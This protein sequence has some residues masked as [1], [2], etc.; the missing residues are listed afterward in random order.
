MTD[1]LLSI[2]LSHAVAFFIGK[3]LSSSSPHNKQRNNATGIN[4]LILIYA[5]IAQKFAFRA[6]PDLLQWNWW[7][8]YLFVVLHTLCFENCD[9]PR[10][11]SCMLTKNTLTAAVIGSDLMLCK[12]FFADR[13]SWYITCCLV[14]VT[15]LGATCAPSDP[16]PLSAS[17]AHVEEQL[18]NV[19]AFKSGFLAKYLPR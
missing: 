4:T 3:T 8:R 17:L 10:P 12:P 16:E 7:T 19:E 6:L 13:I 14:H 15:F 11:W 2:L 18:R 5:S 1:V 9:A